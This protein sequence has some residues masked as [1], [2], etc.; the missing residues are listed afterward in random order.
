[1]IQYGL[2]VKEK[3]AR[4]EVVF[5]SFLHLP[6][7]EVVEIYGLA[8]FD[9]A[10]LDTEHG[11]MGFETLQNMARAADVHQMAS[12][13]RI[14]A[15]AYPRILSVLE[16]ETSGVVVPHVNDADAARTVIREAKYYPLGRRGLAT[17]ARA[18]D[19][20]TVDIADYCR[21]ANEGTLVIVQIENLD[22]AERSE[23]IAAVDGI[24]MLLLG[25]RDMSQSAGVPG[26]VDHPKVAAAM[27]KVVASARAAG[28]YASSFAGSLPFAQKALDMGFQT[29]FYACDTILLSNVLRETI[30]EL[31][32]LREQ[33]Q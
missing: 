22:A 24:D 11:P 9:L 19:Y 31:R 13:V 4:G 26:Q 17:T 18:G 30:A 21:R 32:S 8:G 10:I 25:P 6:S 27:E 7:P 29:I 2:A 28:K 15:G 5:G 33:P 16:I 23:E 20:G 14:P 3:L 12:V 1:M